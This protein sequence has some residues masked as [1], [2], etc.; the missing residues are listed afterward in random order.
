MSFPTTVKTVDYATA[1]PLDPP[2]YEVSVSSN[3]SETPY[4]AVATATGFGQSP[5][6]PAVNYYTA[7][8]TSWPKRDSHSEIGATSGKDWS[9]TS[10]RDW[11]YVAKVI[12]VAVLI[13]ALVAACIFT[14]GAAFA[15]AAAGGSYAMIGLVGGAAAGFGVS[16][17]AAI[18]IALESNLFDSTPGQDLSKTVQYVAFTTIASFYITGKCALRCLRE[19]IILDI[20]IALLK[21]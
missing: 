14:G 16:A 4:P 5:G 10:N 8:E 11:V 6:A 19:G 18:P 7:P 12:T 9:S 15:I 13:A 1:G 20:L 2:S 3:G 17:I 21:K